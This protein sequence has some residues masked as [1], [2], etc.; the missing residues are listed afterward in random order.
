MQFRLIEPLIKRLNKRLC[1]I[2]L[3][4]GVLILCRIAQDFRF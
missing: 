4:V 1:G 3:C 2:E